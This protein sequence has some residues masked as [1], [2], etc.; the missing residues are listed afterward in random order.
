MSGLG[1][2]IIYK[3]ACFLGQDILRQCVRG[4][5]YS[6]CQLICFPPVSAEVGITATQL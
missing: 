4:D 1:V 5:D 2:K 3:M 6:T